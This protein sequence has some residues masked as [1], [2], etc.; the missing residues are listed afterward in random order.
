MCGAKHGVYHSH[1]MFMLVCVNLQSLGYRNKLHGCEIVGV[2]IYSVFIVN[3][4]G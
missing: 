1:V 2:V 3:M 4:V